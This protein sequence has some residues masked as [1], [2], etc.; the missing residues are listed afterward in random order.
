MP[1]VYCTGLYNEAENEI[2]NNDN[3]RSNRVWHSMS[4]LN[5][6]EAIQLCVHIT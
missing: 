4:R 5:P 1:Q 6:E 3:A 2:V